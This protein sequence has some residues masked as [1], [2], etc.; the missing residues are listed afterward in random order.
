MKV[1]LK[2]NYHLKFSKPIWRIIPDRILPVLTIEQ[3]DSNDKQVIYSAYDFIQKR[4]IWQKEITEEQG[5]ETISAMANGKL[6]IERFSNEKTP[7]QRGFILWDIFKDEITYENQTDKFFA[8]EDPGL[9]YIKND[10]HGLE[11]S[12]FLFETSEIRKVEQEF[13]QQNMLQKEDVNKNKITLAQHYPEQN[14]YFK[15]IA[16]FIKENTGGEIVKGADYLDYGNWILIS[17]YIFNQNILSNY[18]YVFNQL[19]KLELNICLARGI[20]TIGLDT[21]FI[22]NAQL[23]FIKDKNELISYELP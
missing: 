20:Q 22:L 5:W 9:I 15:D 10:F 16:H 2:E 17:C 21:F 14:E 3:R 19:G 4:I 18:L 11:Y 23:I 12:L 6:V 7:Q 8:F 1:N 13:I